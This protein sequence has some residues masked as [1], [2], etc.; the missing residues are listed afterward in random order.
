MM[1]EPAVMS[2]GLFPALYKTVELLTDMTE[3]SLLA[4]NPESSEKLVSALTKRKQQARAVELLKDGSKLIK[5]RA[6]CVYARTRLSLQPGP[7]TLPPALAAA[8]RRCRR[9]GARSRARCPARIRA[10][11][12]P[13]LC[14]RLLL[15]VSGCTCHRLAARARSSLRPLSEAA[16]R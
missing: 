1:D 3:S 2:T 5:A 6:V 10:C 11:A 13:S 9:R 14:R 16:G 8:A 12:C 7:G 15:G 4:F